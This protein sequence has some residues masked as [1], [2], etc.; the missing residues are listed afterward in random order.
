M[1]KTFWASVRYDSQA[2][3]RRSSIASEILPAEER[4]L[5]FRGMQARESIEADLKKEREQARE[6]AIDK[7][8]E[9]FW[10]ASL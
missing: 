7:D 8:I 5:Y 2:P 3:F 1:P 4:A 9:D 6:K 10:R